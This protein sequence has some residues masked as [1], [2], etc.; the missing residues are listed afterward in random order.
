MN[1]SRR[2][3]IALAASVLTLP[4]NLVAIEGGRRYTLKS[5][6]YRPNGKGSY[7]LVVLNHGAP[8]NYADAPSQYATFAP[9]SRWFVTRGWA[10]VVPN[11][12]GYGGSTG[13]LAESTGPCSNPD[14]QRAANATADDIVATIAAMRSEPHVD[15]GRVVIAGWSAGGYGTLAAGARNPSGVVGLLNFD[16]GRGSLASGK[17][18]DPAQLVRVAGEFGA[19]AE[20]PSLWLWSRNDERFSPALARQMFAAYTRERP[21]GA[22]SFVLMPAYDG[23]GHGLFD[24]ASE[25]AIWAPYVERFLARL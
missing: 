20:A 3:F 16:G 18:C 13:P 10:V 24:D 22:D 17:N 23:D 25:I 14:F 6:L 12:R 5:T 11:R 19:T 15:S 21:K 8:A 7:P 9:Q 4:L 2:D 1:V